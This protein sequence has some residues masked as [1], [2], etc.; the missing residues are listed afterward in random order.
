MSLIIIKPKRKM[1]VYWSK[2]H[3]KE[4]LQ[5]L[6]VYTLQ[7]I[8]PLH[9]ILQTHDAFLLIFA[10]EKSVV[11]TDTKSD[12]ES[13]T[14]TP[15]IQVQVL[16]TRSCRFFMYLKYPFLD[17]CEQFSLSI[18]YTYQKKSGFIWSHCLRIKNQRA[19][20]IRRDLCRLS[21]PTPLLKQGHLK[22]VAW[23]HVQVVFD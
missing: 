15:L 3:F 23:D 22:L 7:K 1:F 18:F 19:A 4:Q 5:S 6:L 14:T 20:E 11:L 2:G 17:E 21:G 8:L 12:W 9:L 10:R 13:L 16:N